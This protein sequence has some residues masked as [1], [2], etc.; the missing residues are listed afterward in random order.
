MPPGVCPESS[1]KNW[2]H[3]D[4]LESCSAPDIGS[5]AHLPEVVLVFSAL[6]AF[7]TGGFYVAALSHAWCATHRELWYTRGY[8]ALL[9]PAAA[10]YTSVQHL[11]AARIYAI[12]V[13]HSKLHRNNGKLKKTERV[14]F[15][16]AFASPLVYIIIA[17]VAAEG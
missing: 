5:K 4:P 14:L 3:L 17:V 8:D 16:Y 13:D 15:Y 12:L 11:T 1:A 9:M 10:F 7:N 2:S 6:F